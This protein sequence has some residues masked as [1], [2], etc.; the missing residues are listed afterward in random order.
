MVVKLT[1]FYMTFSI[2]NL[3]IYFYNKTILYKRIHRQYKYHIKYLNNTLN[4]IIYIYIGI[5]LSIYVLCVWAMAKWTAHVTI[6][7]R[8]VG[9]LQ[10]GS[11]SVWS[12]LCYGTATSLTLPHMHC[13][14]I[15]QIGMRFTSFFF[16]F[17]LLNM[18]ILKLRI[19]VK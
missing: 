15:S 16:I 18:I 17:I 7:H 19:I 3:N 2:E 8:Q 6:F 4:M 13:F 1:K 11:V 14:P 12:H 9:W 5:Y 10:L